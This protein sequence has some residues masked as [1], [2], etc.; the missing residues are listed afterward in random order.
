MLD[1]EVVMQGQSIKERDLGGGGEGWGLIGS[2]V[3]WAWTARTL[4]L[5]LRLGVKVDDDDED[6]DDDG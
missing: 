4:T 3:F 2:M 6:D 5:T 1:V